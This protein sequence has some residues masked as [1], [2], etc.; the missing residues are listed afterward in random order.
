VR[1][2]ERGVDERVKELRRTEPHPPEHLSCTQ[3]Y[4]DLERKRAL[5]NAQADGEDFNVVEDA[6]FRNVFRKAKDGKSGL[7]SGGGW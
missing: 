3:S 5:D 6:I 7:G 2:S 4:R 1:I